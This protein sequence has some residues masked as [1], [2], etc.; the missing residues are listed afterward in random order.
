MLTDLSGAA[1]V[2]LMGAKAK[3][4]TLR[5]LRKMTRAQRRKWWKKLPKHKKVLLIASMGPV[6]LPLLALGAAVAPVA[7]VPAATAVA[8][9]KVVK[10]VRAKR[11]AK[12]KARIKAAA[13]V[14]HQARAAVARAMPA[15][16]AAAEGP[17]PSIPPWLPLVGVA[18]MLIL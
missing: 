14:R 11:A 12:R 4:M 13:K 15:V 3:R 17:K 7:A 9:A 16:E 8:T 6:L 1:G 5:R 10:R 18:A 2:E